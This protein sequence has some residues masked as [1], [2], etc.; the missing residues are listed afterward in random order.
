VV[1]TTFQQTIAAA[2][3]EVGP[4]EGKYPA[5]AALARQHGSSF[6]D[7]IAACTEHEE[8]LRFSDCCLMA[9]SGAPRWGHCDHASYLATLERMVKIL[10]PM[11]APPKKLWAK[12]KNPSQTVF[13][14]T[15]AEAVW[16]VHFHELALDFAYEVPL[17]PLKAMPKDADFRVPTKD[18]PL[19][20]DSIA[21]SVQS[22]SMPAEKPSATRF[23][24]G[25]S[26]E[27]SVNLFMK[28]A[29]SKYD[30]KFRREV[31][32]GA[33][34]G[35]QTGIL[36]SLLKAEKELLLPFVF[37]GSEGLSVEPP[38]G[39]FTEAR[40]AL[41]CVLVTNFI[42]PEGQEHL[43]PNVLFRWIQT[44]IELCLTGGK[45]PS[46]AIDPSVNLH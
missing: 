16:T 26:K 34:N 19:W 25:R 2:M 11:G 20:L 46:V 6:R 9:A 7:Q 27:A 41:A 1:W 39:L 21:I 13:L 40:S 32:D 37:S 38:N 12:I 8:P 45:E 22:A 44:G 23:F 31:N 5:L 43:V 18:G 30:K 4:L 17:D 24:G 28:K 14:D 29:H 15:V 33:L 42:R 35:Q 10:L 36:L 3:A